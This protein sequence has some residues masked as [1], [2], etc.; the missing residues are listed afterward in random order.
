MEADGPFFSE[1]GIITID[2]PEELIA[3][4]L[5]PS[6]L[7]QPVFKRQEVGS[8][9]T[10]NFLNCKSRLCRFPQRT[11][12]QMAGHSEFG[13]SCIARTLVYVRSYVIAASFDMLT[14]GLKQ[15]PHSIPAS[16]CVIVYL[17][18]PPQMRTWPQANHRSCEISVQ[19]QVASL[20][21]S[22]SNPPLFASS[23]CQDRMHLLTV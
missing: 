21:T 23:W 4:A 16:C 14:Q 9:P 22:M 7:G 18:I 10:L 8:K 6:L 1:S 17:I 13:N 2:L 5:V 11:V 15:H 3:S 20:L 12:S 19:P